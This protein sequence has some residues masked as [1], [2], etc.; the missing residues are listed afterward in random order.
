MSSLP[1]RLVLQVSLQPLLLELLHCA[2]GSKPTGDGT[3]VGHTLC[4]KERG[5]DTHSS[6]NNKTVL[7][8]QVYLYFSEAKTPT[9]PDKAN[10]EGPLE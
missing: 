9:Y 10:S 1:A 5:A 2:G 6:F 3:G 8:S 7:S 4:R